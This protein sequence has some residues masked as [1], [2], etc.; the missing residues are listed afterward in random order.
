M[1]GNCV[2]AQ[3][4]GRTGAWSLQALAVTD[5]CNGTLG[6]YRLFQSGTARHGERDRETKRER[7]T[8]EI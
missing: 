4:P 1:F 8:A 3:T 2:T 7:E 5:T 6:D